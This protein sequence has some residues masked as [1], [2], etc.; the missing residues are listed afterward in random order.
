MLLHIASAIITTN[1]I[2]FSYSYLNSNLT[3]KNFF[4]IE[5]SHFKNMH[6]G[7]ILKKWTHLVDTH[8]NKVDTN[9]EVSTYVHK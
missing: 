6:I 2:R 8:Y 5:K 1:T 4:L 3:T 9:K 7:S